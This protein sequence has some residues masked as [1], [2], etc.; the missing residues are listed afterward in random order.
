MKVMGPEDPSLGPVYSNL[1]AALIGLGRPDEALP[2][3]E[4]EIASAEK[5]A[6]ARS[7]ATAAPPPRFRACR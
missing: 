2:Y 1:S 3:L 5:K 7:L 4:R 6:C